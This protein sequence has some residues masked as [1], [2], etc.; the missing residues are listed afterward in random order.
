M[1]TPTIGFK[2]YLF[3]KSTESLV[4]MENRVKMSTFNSAIGP[5]HVYGLARPIKSDQK[6][7][8]QNVHCLST[9]VF[10]ISFT[11]RLEN[12]FKKA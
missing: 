6:I 2:E 11:G 4:L 9:I 1:K 12:S 7:S 8:G 10:N 3:I 5:E